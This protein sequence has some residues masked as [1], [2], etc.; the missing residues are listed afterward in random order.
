MGVVKV[1][2]GCKTISYKYKYKSN[3]EENLGRQNEET[4]TE[5]VS[6]LTSPF[7]SQPINLATRRRR[8]LW[9]TSRE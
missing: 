1:T 6:A 5:I 8:E 4:T 3:L 7:R 9:V 2:Q